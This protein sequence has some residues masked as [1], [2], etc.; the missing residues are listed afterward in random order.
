M[1]THSKNRGKFQRDSQKKMPILWVLLVAAVICVLAVALWFLLGPGNGDNNI[2]YSPSIDTAVATS[3]REDDASD[4]AITASGESGAWTESQETDDTQ[5]I[6]DDFSGPTDPSVTERNPKETN[7]KETNPK[8]TNPKETN[9]KETNPKETT[10]K[11]T[12]PKE[13]TPKETTPKETTPKETTPKETNPKETTPKETTP[14]ETTPKETTPKETTPKETTPKETTPKETNPKE[15][16]PKE[17]TPKET[18]PKETTPKETTPKET[19]P[20]ET[21]PKETNP[22]E[23]NPKETNPKETTPKETT[24]KETNPKETNPKETNPKETTPK[25]T[26]PKETTP[27]E[28]NP[29]ETTPKETSPQETQPKP[30]PQ[31]Q[32]PVKPNI[33]P[34]YTEPP[35]TEPEI[36]YTEPIDT[37]PEKVVLSLPYTIPNSGIEI[38]RIAPYDGIYME[39]GSNEDVKGIAMILVKN[40]SEEAIEYAEISMKYDDKTLKFKVSALPSGARAILQA[41]NRDSCA[42]GELLACTASVA[43]L[44]SLDQSEKKVSV[45]DNGDNSLT[46][47]NLTDKKIVT[48]R[49]FYKYYMSDENT[50]VGGITFTAKISDLGAGES[51][52]VSPSHFT[53]DSGKVVMIR[54]YDTDV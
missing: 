10:P 17:T 44:P 45:V 27:K 25:E 50:Y 24:P 2:P 7:P 22:K 9:P 3:P 34:S 46:I 49:L 38:L 52:T 4:A 40:I 20:K 1:S 14:K 19:N 16:N 48:I 13:T 8:E 28:T 29:K 11:E 36:E 15:T 35:E 31:P 51:V 42:E 54:T 30:I 26:T 39:D 6:T 53:S 41:E 43:M 21:N 32:L 37:E 33:P 5:S 23:T 47:S 12:T 18:T